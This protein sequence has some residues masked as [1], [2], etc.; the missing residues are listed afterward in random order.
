MTVRFVDASSK[1]LL[2]SKEHRSF[3]LKGYADISELIEDQ[4]FSRLMRAAD[5][6]T[7]RA[8]IRAVVDGAIAKAE[9]E[10]R[11]ADGE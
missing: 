11:E 10:I 5:F 3:D 2:L 9:A 7:T 4:I 8:A 1:W 6:D